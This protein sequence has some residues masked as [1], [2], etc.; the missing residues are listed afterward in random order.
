MAF[1]YQQVIKFIVFGCHHLKDFN[2]IHSYSKGNPIGLL[3]LSFIETFLMVMVFQFV[4]VNS[5]GKNNENVLL[6][7]QM[8][9]MVINY[10]E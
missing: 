6:M 8:V 4:F 7:N 2:Y 3:N 9:E 10:R 1:I 5:K